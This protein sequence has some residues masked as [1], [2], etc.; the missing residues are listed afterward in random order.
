VTFTAAV[1]SEW[2]V[3][4]GNV[5][6]MMGATVLAVVS[7]DSAGQARYILASPG[8]GSHTITAVYSGDDVHSGNSASSTITVPDAPTVTDV[9]SRVAVTRSG[10]TFNRATGT[11]FQTLTIRNTSSTA[12]TGPISLVLEG[13]PAG[14]RLVNASG[15]TQNVGQP[16]S[17]YVDL[18]GPDGVLAPGATLTVVLEFDNPRKVGITYTTRVLAGPGTR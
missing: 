6:F 5:T 13:L 14:V 8:P 4:G 17:P 10:F 2:G 3:P 15:T 18:L 16:G 7:L 12:I 11:F 1:G 9:S